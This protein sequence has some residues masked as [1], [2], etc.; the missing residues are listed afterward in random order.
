[1]DVIRQIKLTI[2]S[3]LK[4]T[5]LVGNAVHS[6]CELLSFHKGECADIELC[7]IEGINNAVKHAYK[8]QSG[9]DI[10]IVLAVKTD[11]LVIEIYDT[12]MGMDFNKIKVPDFDS[13]NLDSV[14]ESGMGIYI[15]KSIMNEVCYSR[16]HAKNK[17]T[18]T[19]YLNPSVVQKFTEKY[20]NHNEIK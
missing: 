15:I 11:R 13:N 19:R 2:D 10:D 16:E 18:M 1:M 6:L 9:N 8:N 5:I 7:V 20:Q 12:G 17:L 4:N 3:D 14:P